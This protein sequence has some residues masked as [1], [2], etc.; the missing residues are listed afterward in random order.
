M[1]FLKFQPSNYLEMR[2]YLEKLSDS[3][4]SLSLGSLSNALFSQLTTVSFT[5]LSMCQGSATKL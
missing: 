3:Y 5:V 2:A 4:T 1:S